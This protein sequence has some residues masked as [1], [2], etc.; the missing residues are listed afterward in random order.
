MSR[1]RLAC[2]LSGYGEPHRPCAPLHL[3]AGCEDGETTPTLRFR[4]EG[5]RAQMDGVERADHRRERFG[6]PLLDGVGERDDGETKAD[7]TEDGQEIGDRVVVQEPL[8]A[9]PVQCAG[10]LDQQ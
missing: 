8:E 7:G 1:A 10:T 6:G 2:A 5:C 9:L 3:P 4:P